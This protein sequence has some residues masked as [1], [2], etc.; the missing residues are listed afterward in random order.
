M[1][2]KRV[3]SLASEEYLLEL[4][5]KINFDNLS[6]H[7]K[8]I[9]GSINELHD[10]MGSLSPELT[11]KTRMYYGTINLS[12]IENFKSFKNLTK[13][14][15]ENSSNITIT[16]PGEREKQRITDVVPG[17]CVLVVIPAF[18][19]LD[20]KKDDGFGE[21]I[22]FDESILGANGVDIT[23]DKIPY[24]V[25]G[26]F[27]MTS[28]DRIVHIYKTSDDLFDDCL[29]EDITIEDIDNI[30]SDVFNNPEN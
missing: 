27:A 8:T 22:D 29:C 20:V 6:T 5:S 1:G 10:I 23:I 19:N 9:L 17:S 3:L 4:I 28:G 11:T 13:E 14:M 12:E 30:M 25:Y 15:L 26:E 16:M 24:R 21:Q 2:K 18:F 7:D